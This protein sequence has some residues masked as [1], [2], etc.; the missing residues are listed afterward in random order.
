MVESDS[1]KW[2]WLEN[3]RAARR[4]LEQIAHE[5]E[6]TSDEEIAAIIGKIAEQLAAGKTS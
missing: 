2:K 6:K 5:F 4:K 1:P 3:K